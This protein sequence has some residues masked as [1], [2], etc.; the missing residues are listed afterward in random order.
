MATRGDTAAERSLLTNEARQR[1]RE[2]SKKKGHRAFKRF[3]E[4]IGPQDEMPPRGVLLHGIIGASETM[5]NGRR[6][7]ARGGAA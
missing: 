6:Y 7:A 3:P 4:T 1:F 5:G 2:V